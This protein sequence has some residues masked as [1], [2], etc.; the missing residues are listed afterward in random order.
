M[1]DINKTP[2]QIVDELFEKMGMKKPTNQVVFPYYEPQAG[3][4]VQKTIHDFILRQSKQEK[5]SDDSTK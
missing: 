2:E 3:I 4:D 5:D 1:S